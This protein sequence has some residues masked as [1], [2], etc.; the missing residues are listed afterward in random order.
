LNSLGERIKSIRQECHLSQKNFGLRINITHGHLSAIEKNKVKPSERLIKLICLN[1]GINEEWL[2]TGK[3]AKVKANRPPGVTLN[4][5]IRNAE[6][7]F[8][9]KPREVQEMLILVLNSL[10]ELLDKV[11]EQDHL[12]G[13]G[14]D[15][16]SD[17][18]QKRLAG[19]RAMVYKLDQICCSNY[20]PANELLENGK[21]SELD[22]YEK[23]R[24]IFRKHLNAVETYLEEFFKWRCAELFAE[25]QQNYHTV[26][27]AELFAEHQRNYQTMELEDV[28]RQDEKSKQQRDDPTYFQPKFFQEYKKK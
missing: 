18:T 15:N 6:E 7:Y 16:Y 23:K 28:T 1:F 13:L 22:F 9:G 25:Y 20:L 3:D 4:S 24:K 26:E 2:R 27:R 21:L 17:L 8:Q 5:F 10:C 19:I 11:V 12:N 14:P